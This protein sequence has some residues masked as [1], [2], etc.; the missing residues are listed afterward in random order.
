MIKEAIEED[1]AGG[2]REMDA[3]ELHKLNEVIQLVTGFKIIRND[4][5][6]KIC[7]NKVPDVFGTPDDQ[8]V[9]CVGSRSSLVIC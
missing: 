3:R 1:L 4:G 5:K 2:Y 7:R 8:I 6:K 9:F